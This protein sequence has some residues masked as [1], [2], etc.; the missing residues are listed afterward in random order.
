MA[1]TTDQ[2]TNAARKD[3]ARQP[4]TIILWWGLPIAV[5][6]SVSLLHPPFRVAAGVCAVAFAWMAT[7]C[8]LNAR[9]C[10]RVHCYISGPVLLLFA[11]KGWAHPFKEAHAFPF[12]QII[13]MPP[14][15]CR[16]WPVT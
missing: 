13:A 3:W 1:N 8:L 16:V 14:L 11:A 9:R 7:G 10:H 15:T 6:V 4:L 5:G 2:V 12:A